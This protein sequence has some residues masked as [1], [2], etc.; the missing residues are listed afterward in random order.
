MTKFIHDKNF[1]SFSSL[2]SLVYLKQLYDMFLFLV[3]FCYN[4]VELCGVLQRVI[5]VCQ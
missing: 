4:I 1:V 5:D 3:A 2:L